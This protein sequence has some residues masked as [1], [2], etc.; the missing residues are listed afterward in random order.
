MKTLQSFIDIEQD[1]YARA[2][3]KGKR[4]SSKAARKTDKLMRERRKNKHI[5][6]YS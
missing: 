5:M 3:G 6:C 4:I 2:K 1:M